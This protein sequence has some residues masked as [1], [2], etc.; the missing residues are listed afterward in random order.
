MRPFAQ[1]TRA[2][3]RQRLARAAAAALTHYGITDARLTFRSDT[4][5]T[6]FRA[7]A[8]GQRFALR[9]HPAQGWGAPQIHA[10]LA[11]LTALRRDLGLLVPEPV[12]TLGG[13]PLCEID[14]P[15]IP[16]RRSVALF[17]WISGRPMGQ[18]I[19]RARLAQLG[20]LMA[21]LHQHAMTFALPEGTDRDRDD[22][23]GMREWR[24]ASH[25]SAGILRPDQHALCAEAAMRAADVIAQIDP[26]DNIG[27]IHS[28]IH[29]ANCLDCGE[30]LGLIDFDDCQFAPF[31]SDLAITLTYLDDRPDY[32]LLRDALLDG[33]SQLR[34]L[35]AGAA[36]ELDAFMV[37]RGLRLILWVASWPSINH[38]PFGQ[39]II[40]TTLRR[41]ARW[42]G[43]GAQ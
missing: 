37:E 16:G 32:A 20:R 30:Q 26:H 41:C 8:A 43:E 38:F 22:W 24:L 39:A 18:Q 23:P 11:W 12:P 21:Q 36:A 10:E 7:E 5:N 14:L 3:Q 29:F 31:T 28:D 40:D 35:P 15:G 17:R 27:L 25:P 33:Y 2:S 34:P 13:R 42:L 6:V 9:I 4:T 1:L 19:T